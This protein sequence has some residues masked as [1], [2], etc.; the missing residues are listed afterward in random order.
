[1]GKAI[2]TKL[3]EWLTG[4]LRDHFSEKDVTGV[5]YTPLSP[6]DDAE[7]SEEYLSALK[8]ALDNRKTI[9][10]I[11][12]TGPYGSGKSSIIKTFQQKH[13]FNTD[14]K[15]L[16]ISLATFKDEKN[17]E[18]N[19]QSAEQD[20]E[21]KLRLIELSLL[22]QIFYHEIDSKI[23]DSRFSRII[24]QNKKHI[25]LI[26][27]YVF[28]VLLSYWMVFDFDSVS[29]LLGVS[30]EVAA[31]DSLKYLFRLV[32]IS[33]VLV[34]IY[35]AVQL[36]TRIAVKKV[37]INNSE[38]EIDEKIS[39]SI[40]N[41]HLDEIL[42][43][44]EVTDCNIV[45]IEDLDRFEQ[46]EV[47]TKLREL[48]LLL[49]N[50]KKINQKKDIVFIYAIRDEMFQNKDRAKFFDFLI[51]VIPVINSS[52]SNE[53]LLKK[54]KDNNYK[55]SERLV[56]DIS[57]F[58]DDMRLLYNIL[59]EYHIY[60]E[61]I[62]NSLVAN[63]LFA[64]ITY[65]NMYPQDFSNL[66][67]NKGTLYEALKSKSK[68]VA[69]EVGKID[70]EIADHK[71]RLKEIED[72]TLKSVSEL[73]SIY[74]LGIIKR[75]REKFNTPFYAFFIQ[76][77][78]C[79]I[80][81][82]LADDKFDYLLK[83]F[84]TVE[85]APDRSHYNRRTL[86]FNFSEVENAV[87]PQANY[88]KR[89]Q[90]IVDASV[91]KT[92]DRKKKIQE[93]EQRRSSV[94]SLKLKDL[95][96]DN[97]IQLEPLTTVDIAQQDLLNILLRKGYIDESYFDYI[98]IFYEVS[99]SRVD[100]DFLLNL[101]AQKDLDIADV[102]LE[103]IENL[104]KKIE[105]FEF[106]NQYVLNYSLVEYITKMPA[107]AEHRLKLFYQL[108]NGSDRSI[109]FI[110]GFFSGISEHALFVKYLCK[111][112]GGFWK[113][114]SEQSSYPDEKKYSYFR[115]IIVN[116]D[117]D[118]LC[119]IFEKHLEVFDTYPDFLL[120]TPDTHK[121][122]EILKK[123]N[124]KLVHIV[125]GISEEIL[126]YIYLKCHYCINEDN[127]RLMIEKYATADAIKSFNTANYGCVSESKLQP[128]IDY[129]HSDINSY[130]ELVYLKIDLNKEE[131]IEK[132]GVLLKNENV[133]EENKEKI[134]EYTSTKF[135]TTEAFDDLVIQ[136]FAFKYSKI[137]ATWENVNRSFF[138]EDNKFSTD[139]IGFLNKPENYLLLKKKKISKEF[140][141]EKKATEF[142]AA[143]IKENSL[144]LEAYTA[145]MESLPYVYNWIGLESL[146][147]N[148]VNVLL[149]M[150]KLLVTKENFDHLK[151]NFSHLR[152]K[153]FETDQ[154]KF[155]SEFEKFALD[156]SD[157]QE[158]ISSSVLSNY[159]KEKVISLNAFAFYATNGNLINS[160]ARLMLNKNISN[161]AEDLVRKFV[162]N[163]TI[164]TSEK[165]KLFIKFNDKFNSE[166]L[167]SN[168]LQTLEEPFS[169]IA[170]KGK[171]PRL[172]KSPSNQDFV[173]LL[174][175]KDYI[176][177]F[178]DSRLTG[179]KIVVSTKKK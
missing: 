18:E 93:L 144:D 172:D 37:S 147:A 170:N 63:N 145:L 70:K 99:I 97:R 7:N 124:L 137:D 135:L 179:D 80:D 73:R 177:S 162:I 161:I 96:S 128:L 66:S 131:S 33:A 105:V 158:I 16:N 5:V 38:I 115:S 151:E 29:K 1:M 152:I 46:T 98:S 83:N 54:I 47:F 138:D 20:G 178:R 112:W 141:E 165:I 55:I 142:I 31:N 40:L 17:E 2:L 168:F 44:F 92:N 110:D 153:L 146:D 85:Y 30:S 53:K 133:T 49:N 11:A 119:L 150:K 50:S 52:N 24:T 102:R 58:I 125:S 111:H 173:R 12:I 159:L 157:V 72:I 169:N 140:P 136:N 106:E 39:K 143:L 148:K 9:K 104:L 32:L 130:I 19:D 149:D 87:E 90:L 10:N 6:V 78:E 164:G 82:F 155:V 116:A 167:I 74:I 26:T 56:D 79:G 41:K 4:L 117:L 34:A 89:H 67:A 122:K 113:Y 27:F 81:Q 42:Y 94:K 103:K 48:N 45:V 95:M 139:V 22:Q 171:S 91:K 14:Y 64:M 176:S 57:M 127:L 71:S 77:T 69:L 154:D 132:L 160:I 65:K 61:K 62:G 100:Y 75:I 175:T 156:A 101:R 163:S 166:E 59:N 28:L 51:P 3:I 36:V 23:P 35:K 126:K 114:I 43:F 86:S 25:L 118:D 174:K 13:S 88:K 68:F 8:W 123:L 15:F 108:A 109:Q 134:I 121:L 107:Y 60:H 76:G 84:T 120:M 21:S 129:V